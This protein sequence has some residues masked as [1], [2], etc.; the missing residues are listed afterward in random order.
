MLSHL[1]PEDVRRMEREGWT[2]CAKC[3]V[4]FWF[5]R[6]GEKCLQ[7]QIREVIHG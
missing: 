1:E 7:C 3:G 4:P 2:L 5:P 6:N